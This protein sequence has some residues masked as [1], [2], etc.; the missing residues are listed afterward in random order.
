MS[1]PAKVSDEDIRRALK[2]W[3]GVVADAR[4]ALGISENALR[5]RLRSMGIGPE[6]LSFLRSG[7]LPT[8]PQ[9]T[10]TITTQQVGTKERSGQHLPLKSGGRNYPRPVEAPTL[11]D[12]SMEAIPA[13]RPQTKPP[14]LRPDQ[15]DRLRDMKFDYQ[16]RHRTETDEGDLLQ[17][18]FDEAFPDWEKRALGKEKAK[19]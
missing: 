15:V 3:R 10:T 13:R 1:A 2:V 11:R 14:K 18:F 16:A 19:A 9:P 4:R 17:R 5:K 6:A 12:V 8:Q 7:N